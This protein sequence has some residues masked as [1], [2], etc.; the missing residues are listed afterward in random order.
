MKLS[1]RQFSGI[2]TYKD[3]LGPSEARVAEDCFVGDGALTPVPDMENGTPTGID[4]DR[5][6]DDEQCGYVEYDG[7]I[8]SGCNLSGLGLPQPPAPGVTQ[9][10]TPKVIGPS[11]DGSGS[12]NAVG[13]WEQLELVQ[14]NHWSSAFTDSDGNRTTFN[15]TDSW[16]V[17]DSPGFNI[18]EYY[19][20]E[21]ANPTLAKPAPQTNQYGCVI[22]STGGGFATGPGDAFVPKYFKDN[23]SY[24]VAFYNEDEDIQSTVSN[25]VEFEH[26]PYITHMEWSYGPL[27]GDTAGK[28]WFVVAPSAPQGLFP[29]EST[30]PKDLRGN[31]RQQVQYTG[32]SHLH[33][34]KV[35]LPWHQNA[36]HVILYKRVGGSLTAVAK[37]SPGDSLT[38]GPHGVFE[39]NGAGDDLS[40]ESDLARFRPVFTRY[41]APPSSL[42][43]IAVNA[44]G[45]MV[46]IK[47]DTVHIS[48]PMSG[49]HL[50]DPRARHT[51]NHTPLTVHQIYNEFLITTEGK[52]VKITGTD[53]ATMVPIE[54]PDLEYNVNWKS[55]ADAGSHVMWAGPNG[56][57]SYDGRS[58]KPV[59]RGILSYSDWKEIRQSS[60]LV[61]VASDE[62][63][64]LFHDGGA[65]IV[66]MRP[67]SAGLTKWNI[68][69]TK[70]VYAIEEGYIYLSGG[71]KFRLDAALVKEDAD[72]QGYWKSGRLYIGNVNHGLAWMRGFS[73][74][75]VDVVV[76]NEKNEE[77]AFSITQ[78]IPQRVG[79]GSDVI[80]GE[81]IEVEL[82]FKN[83]L[84]GVEFASTLDELQT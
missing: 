81:W 46:G 17:C 23:T 39:G 10:D 24:A 49:F 36:T 77:A 40:L 78:P 51:L 33:Q 44:A 62:V 21:K 83:R 6:D 59:T 25:I 82:R 72:V 80:N 22:G 11:E 14:S 79:F 41:E 67:E 54:L 12:F 50:W 34:V 2:N 28:T 73:K 4:K 18:T 56:V 27:Q 8:Y 61:G 16:V 13:E 47:G 7:T 70:A 68:T 55:A 71:R 5:F 53:P 37:A 75:Y 48:Q 45:I 19:A 1:L 3:E 43:S 69:A 29:W 76:R 32:I 42:K 57:A 52:P 66:D 65:L 31:L 35:N 63:Y 84:T 60:T 9:G 20:L 15:T 26:V 38:I 64:I 74:G 58:V 30:D